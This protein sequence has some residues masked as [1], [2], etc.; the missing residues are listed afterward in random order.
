[1][2]ARKMACIGL[3]VIT[4]LLAIANVAFYPP[5]TA[6]TILSILVLGAFGIFII[7]VLWPPEPPKSPAAK[8]IGFN[9]NGTSYFDGTRRILAQ[10]AFVRDYLQPYGANEEYKPFVEQAIKNLYHEGRHIPDL[11]ILMEVIQK[12]PQLPKAEKDAWTKFI[13]LYTRRFRQ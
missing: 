7:L 12:D 11:T 5:S 3:F 4:L 6:R 13:D 9:W 2:K 1:M 10:E 8:I